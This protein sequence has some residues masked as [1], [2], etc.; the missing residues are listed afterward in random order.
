MNTDNVI[1][2]RKTALLKN[3]KSELAEKILG[4]FI[5]PVCKLPMKSAGDSL[6]CGNNHE[7]SMDKGYPD[8]IPYSSGAL[9]EKMMQAEFH[10]DEERNEKFDEIVLRP[11]NSTKAHADSWLYGLKYFKKTLISSLGI[12]LENTL[13]LNCGCGGGFEAQYLAANGAQ[14]VGFDISRLRVEAAAT[15]FALNGNTGFFY[16]GDASLLPFPDN[17]FDI[18]LY[19]DALHH[20]P[21]EEIPQAFREAARVAKRCVALLEAN[22]SP[23]SLL[24][25]SLGHATSVERAGNYVF[26]FR[27]SLMRFWASQ[28]GM[29]LK[30]FSS[31][32]TKKEHWPKFYAL[33]VGGWLFYKLVRFMGLFLGPVG[34]EAC[35]ILEK[36]NSAQER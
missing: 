31:M 11:Y 25:E 6:K 22:D 13:I 19:H 4:L 14:V 20:V 8:F 36:T 29:E 17:T 24:L 9:R 28:T 10:D 2:V 27:P 33:P 21:I 23:L 30:R 5:C 18:V 16:R 7:V 15:R 12:G 34:N 3:M 26:R 35:I 32:F 1:E